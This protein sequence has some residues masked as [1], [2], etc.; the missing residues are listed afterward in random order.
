VAFIGSFNPSGDEPELEPEVLRAVG[1]QNRGHNLLVGLRDPVLVT[2]LVQHAR[3]LHRRWHSAFDRVLPASNR[4][5]RS[6]DF[7]VYFMPRI[8]RD[9]VVALLRRCG[10][11]D[12]VRIAAS[13]F[14]GPTSL[15]ILRALRRRGASV[16]IRAEATARRVPA[17]VEEHLR[18][19]GVVFE[20][21][22]DPDGLPMHAKFALIERGGE[23]HAALG[24]FNWTEP[25][26]LFNR[27]I[28]AI[29]ANREL[30]ARLDA[31]WDVLKSPTAAAI[32]H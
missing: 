19:V 24:S 11:G 17:R 27:E 15:A 18:E 23:R 8:L 30:F 7:E 22:I 10:R 4:T 13:H 29:S 12:R 20:R 31:R 21:V 2:G 6:D 5:L 16:E 1:D 9:P 32:R 14:S 25:S 26:R 3:A 28:G